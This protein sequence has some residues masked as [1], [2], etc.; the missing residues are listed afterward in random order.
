MIDCESNKADVRQ[1]SG[2][3]A[4]CQFLA[5][6]IADGGC[7]SLGGR[8]AMAAE[9]APA[10]GAGSA[11][12]QPAP[13]GGHAAGSAGQT[14]SARRSFSLPDRPPGEP[15][16]GRTPNGALCAGSPDPEGFQVEG[17]DPAGLQCGGAAGGRCTGRSEGR[18]LLTDAACA[19]EPGL[20]GRKPC[21]G[22]PGDARLHHWGA[23]GEAPLSAPSLSSWASA[24]KPA[25]GNARV[26]EGVSRVA[27]SG[28]SLE[29]MVRGS[30]SYAADPLPGSPQRGKCVTCEGLVVVTSVLQP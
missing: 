6:A 12:T 1:M 18:L 9:A 22:L 7:G 28:A 25:K 16:S 8:R 15:G 23:N 11:P 14:S 21:S 10:G 4:V 20:A 3:H 19:C 5:N 30:R 13:L 2:P 26:A 27:D 24:E 29:S 17:S